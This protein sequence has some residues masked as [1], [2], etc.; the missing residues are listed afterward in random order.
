MKEIR[1]YIDAKLEGRRPVLIGHSQGG[2]KCQSYLLGPDGDCKLDTSSKAR[3][4][5]LMASSGAKVGEAVLA[6][7]SFVVSNMGMTA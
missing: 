6:C 2:S 7:T 5:V 3:A 1:E 4:I